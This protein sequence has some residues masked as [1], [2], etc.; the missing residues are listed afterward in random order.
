MDACKKCQGLKGRFQPDYETHLT[1][2]KLHYISLKLSIPEQREH[3]QTATR[4]STNLAELI[5]KIRHLV[6]RHLQRKTRTC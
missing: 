1:D 6:I 4:Q 2:R 5:G 3:A